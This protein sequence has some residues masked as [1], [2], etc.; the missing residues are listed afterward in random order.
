MGGGAGGGVRDAD[1]ELTPNAAGESAGDPCALALGLLMT[2]LGLGLCTGASGLGAGAVGLGLAPE[3]DH[4][5]REERNGEEVL[6]GKELEEAT[7]CCTRKQAWWRLLLP[8]V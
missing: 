4:A 8:V 2:G 7:R 6:A 5:G 3:N 1:G